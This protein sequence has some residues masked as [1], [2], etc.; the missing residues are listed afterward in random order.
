MTIVSDRPAWCGPATP[1]LLY[2]HY[3]HEGVLLYVGSS[4]VYAGEPVDIGPGQ[5]TAA[6]LHVALLALLLPRD[7]ASAQPVEDRPLRSDGSKLGGVRS[8]SVGALLAVYPCDVWPPACG[9]RVVVLAGR[10][11]VRLSPE[12]VSGAG[13][14]GFLLL[15]GEHPVHHIEPITR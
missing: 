10:V 9:F 12:G 2:R 8:A 1:G 7:H 4:D 11:P 15:R 14:E 5:P 13:R 3:D 6:H